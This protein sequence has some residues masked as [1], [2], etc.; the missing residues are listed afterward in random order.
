LL[1]DGQM[2]R[3]HVAEIC[4]RYGYRDFHEGSALVNLE[5]VERLSPLPLDHVSVLG[6]YEFVLAKSI[7]QGKL[8][9]LRD[10]EQLDNLA[11]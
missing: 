9:S 4:R 6:R 8:R 1:R 11:A 3:D 2:R 7:Q 5:D 10:S